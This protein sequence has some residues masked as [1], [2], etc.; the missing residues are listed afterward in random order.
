MVASRTQ[1][2]VLYGIPCVGK[3]TGALAFA[4]RR[5][6]RTVVHTDYLREV[7]RR[8]VP[9]E[10]VPVIAKVTHN[11]W[12]LYGSPTRANILAGFVDHVAAVSPA[13]EV[14]VQKLV[15]D[16][17]ESVIE[18]VHFHGEVI[19]RLRSQNRDADIRA[20]LLVVETAEELRQRAI[21]KGHARTARVPLKEWQE[22][23]PVMLTIQEFLISDALGNDIEITTAVDWR[24]S[25]RP[26]DTLPLT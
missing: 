26:S 21:S 15:S 17:F 23:I 3:S 11:A 22:N 8:Y 13:I 6:I 16:G 4:Q 5:D 18:G 10:T 14:V 2:H 19:Q 12:Q 25:W 20:T 1:I 7:Q 24:K 9:R